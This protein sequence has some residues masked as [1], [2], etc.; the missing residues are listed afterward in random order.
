MRS[1]KENC[2]RCGGKGRAHYSSGATYHGGA[3]T[4]SLAWD[5]CDKCWG[6]GDETDPFDNLRERNERWKQRVAAA[7]L[8]S[9][10]KQLGAYVEPRHLEYIAEAI[11]ALGRKRKLPDG[12]SPFWWSMYCEGM[13]SYL[14]DLARDA[15]ADVERR[16][17]DAPGCRDDWD[18]V[19]D[20]QARASST[21]GRSIIGSR[22]PGT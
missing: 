12:A 18:D 8:E 2:S 9:I 20:T 15:R 10:C 21:Q 13:A 11:A 6:S 1:L 14:R 19:T 22:Q 7:G 17:P 4:C 16:N 5:I 3:G